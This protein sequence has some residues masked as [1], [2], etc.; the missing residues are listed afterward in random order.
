LTI[1]N[2]KGFVWVRVSY[3]PPAEPITSLPPVTLA[4]IRFRVKA[5]GA[6]P[7][8]LH[9]TSLTDSLGQPIPHESFDG[10]FILIRD[11]AVKNVVTSTAQTYQGQTVYINATVKNEGNITETFTV[12]AYYDD[13]LIGTLP[14]NNLAAGSSTTLTFN[15][16]TTDAAPCHN[17][18]IKAKASQVPY[19]TDIADNTYIDGK[20][21]IKMIGD[22]TGDGTV[23]IFDVTI[24]A[25]AFGSRSGEP[26]WDERADFRPPYGLIDIFDLVV[27]AGQ[28]GKSC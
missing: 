4:T 23:D 2:L 20:V 3:Y 7:L 19:E 6:T 17:Y 14:V 21:K 28:F 18:T 1:N 9:D 26:K 12:S 16:D 5:L 11:V 22:L 10:Y 27:I 24:A 25:A 15:W 8:D 13:V